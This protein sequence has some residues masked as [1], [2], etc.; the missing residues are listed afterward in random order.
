[1]RRTF[2]ADE[3]IAHADG[4]RA[5]AHGLLVDANAADDLVQDACVAALTRPPAESVPP[6]AWFVGVVRNLA[7]RSHRS[8]ANRLRRE[9]CV[10]KPESVPSSAEAVAQLETHR[11][12]VEVVMVL[13]DPY[14]TAIV[15]R[16]FDGL[17]PR[18][19]AERLGVPANTVHTWTHRGLAMLRARLETER[20][21]WRA[22]LLPLLDSR[23]GRPPI[24]PSL[25]FAGV[26]AMTTKQSAAI[27]IA[28]LALFGVAA[29]VFAVVKRPAAGPAGADLA[30]EDAR[31]AP[32]RQRAPV[33][34]GDDAIAMAP[35][36][37]AGEEVAIALEPLI[38]ALVATARGNEWSKTW[39]VMDA[40]ARGATRHPDE[41][42]RL[43]EDRLRSLT[44]SERRHVEA[45]LVGALGR[46][47]DLELLTRLFDLPVPHRIVYDALAQDRGDSTLSADGPR[48]SRLWVLTDIA[49]PELR[50]R[51]LGVL[52]RSVS[53]TRSGSAAAAQDAAALVSILALS[54]HRDS[55]VDAYLRELILDDDEIANSAAMSYLGAAQTSHLRDVAIGVLRNPARAARVGPSALGALGR[56]GGD[57][58]EDARLLLTA[59]RESD[60][61]GQ[62]AILQGLPGMLSYRSADNVPQSL[63]RL[64]REGLASTDPRLRDAAA[65]AA[66][67]LSNVFGWDGLDLDPVELLSRPELSSAA[68]ASVLR[69]W[70]GHYVS[71]A[72]VDHRF[73]EAL[74]DR[75]LPAAARAAAWHVFERTVAAHSDRVPALAARLIDR[76]TDEDLG[77]ILGTHAGQAAPVEP[78]ADVA[79]PTV[80]AIRV[81]IAESDTV[82]V[83]IREVL[84]RGDADARLELVARL[85]R[86]AQRA[87]SRWLLAIAVELSS[88]PSRRVAARNDELL[89]RLLSRDRGKTAALLA[90]V[91]ARIGRS[92]SRF[93][94][95]LPSTLVSACV[96]RETSTSVRAAVDGF[97]EDTRTPPGARVVLIEAV[98][99]V[100]TN[101]GDFNEWAARWRADDG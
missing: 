19:I 67:S 40:F 5:L 101:D 95:L 55:T 28:S 33:E 59:Y 73:E 61:R 11:R 93:G 84:E 32:R 3:L 51:L 50:A 2:T 26:L 80:D 65:Y 90:A 71:S 87:S 91:F 77:A 69:G 82:P 14:R 22:A 6:R 38:E 8:R 57:P 94:R 66:G 44:Q 85:S 47:P 49:E 18:E 98:R 97:L 60:R 43:V 15:L 62:I 83:E 70:A 48:T 27:L 100:T 78:G 25:P 88:D 21:D 17:A 29:G 54:A 92:T 41:A 1:M 4:V 46:V 13:S 45:A 7:R 81:A 68:K 58:M 74:A 37:D 12:L 35:R 30:P 20:D 79:V 53:R 96:G 99:A 9:R 89:A 23:V 63:L 72:E 52:Q 31:A 86:G 39:K 10:A 36:T 75:S 34:V 76:E 24:V 16:Y 56:S 64:L 42:F